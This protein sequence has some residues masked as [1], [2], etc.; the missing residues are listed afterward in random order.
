[1]N[2]VSGSKSDRHHKIKGNNNEYRRFE[3][4]EHG[5]VRHIRTEYRL[6]HVQYHSEH[7]CL[8]IWSI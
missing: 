7:R 5:L 3:V 4:L 8:N 1:M 6:T 2:K